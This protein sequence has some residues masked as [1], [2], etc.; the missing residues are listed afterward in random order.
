MFAFESL[1]NE[2]QLIWCILKKMKMSKKKQHLYYKNYLG[3]K[4]IT[5]YLYFTLNV[6]FFGVYLIYVLFLLK[7][8]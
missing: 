4:Y 3:K 1:K 6:L 2:C 8:L 7:S 5:V